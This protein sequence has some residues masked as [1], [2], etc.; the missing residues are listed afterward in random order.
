[1][2]ERPVTVTAGSFTLD[3]T[4]IT[5]TPPTQQVLLL[6]YVFKSWK[7]NL[8]NTANVDAYGLWRTNTDSLD[9]QSKL[10]F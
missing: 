7:S 2:D 10:S 8:F 1:M 6:L 3:I 4:T 5:S 9:D